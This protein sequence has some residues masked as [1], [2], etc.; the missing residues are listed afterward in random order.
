MKTITFWMLPVVLLLAACGGP[1]LVEVSDAD[2]KIT[3]TLSNAQEGDTVKLHL[4]KNFSSDVELVEQALV[5]ANGKVKF[6]YE[7]AQPGIVRASIDANRAMNLVLEPGDRPVVNGE[8]DNF[9]QFT[10]EGSDET[11]RYQRFNVAR[12]NHNKTA[13]PSNKR[14]QQAAAGV[15]MRDLLAI[16]N[17]KPGSVVSLISGGVIMELNGGRIPN[18]FFEVYNSLIE[19]TRE[20]AATAPQFVAIDSYL[21]PIRATMPGQPAPELM[22]NTPEG[23]PLAL[24]SLRGKTVLID[25][26]ASWCGPCRRENPNVKRVY[27]KYK[28]QGFEIYGV[29]LDKGKAKWVEAIQKDGLPW[30]HVS[31]LQGWGSAAAK[32]YSVTSIPQTFL[33]GPDGTILERGLR[34]PALEQ[35]LAEIFPS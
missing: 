31:D 29:S 18:D 15:L 2:A 30:L 12:L 28:D 13:D 23:Q 17:E 14:S 34:G 6:A 20:Y 7:V 24:S 26:W 35:K 1:S 11:A 22:F 21:A 4:F 9:G 8:L 10:I 5:G 3:M 16:M 19:G 32:I 25:F 27:D 33:V